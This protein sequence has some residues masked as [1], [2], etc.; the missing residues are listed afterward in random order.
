[1]DSLSVLQN[2]DWQEIKELPVFC[3]NC[4]T[5]LP[6]DSMFCSNCGNP[7]SVPPFV[8][9]KPGVIPAAHIPSMGSPHPRQVQAPPYGQIP[10]Q[11]QINITLPPPE[12]V[13]SKWETPRVIIG[14]VT[15]SLFFLMQFQSCVAGVGESIAGL[16]SEN[17]GTSG[18]TGYIASFFFLAAGIVSIVCRKSKG[19]SIAAAC[20]YIFCGLMISSED[21]S[22][23]GDLL[24]Y[25]FLS[26]AFGV[27][28]II[29]G[30]TQKK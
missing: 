8:V 26:F 16:F 15:V 7:V 14:I 17:A 5:K 3:T 29:G 1:M 2:S 23:F 22:Y 13:K 4:G 18:A 27:I 12:R 11:Q 25:C 20:I 19:G 30:V 21:F 24:V 6:D 28:M 9:Q 10:V